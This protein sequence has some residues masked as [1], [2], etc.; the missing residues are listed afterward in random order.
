MAQWTVTLDPRV[1]RADGTCEVRVLTGAVD[2]RG[3]PLYVT[4]VLRDGETVR[5]D[6]AVTAAALDSLRTATEGKVL[7][8]LVTRPPA[9]THDV[10]VKTREPLPESTRVR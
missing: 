1:K 7:S 5:T 10:D 4:M 6:D 2:G 3:R 9:P 8:A